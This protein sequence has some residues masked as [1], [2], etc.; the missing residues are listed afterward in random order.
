ML[1]AEG[2]SIRKQP[3]STLDSASKRYHYGCRYNEMSVE[4]GLL[5]KLQPKEVYASTSTNPLNGIYAL[6]LNYWSRQEI[7][8]CVVHGVAATVYEP[9]LRT[10]PQRKPS[11]IR[12]VWTS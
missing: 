12:K 11:G 7:V 1:L 10:K 2:R 9:P 8:V 5:G 4:C 6:D 3:E